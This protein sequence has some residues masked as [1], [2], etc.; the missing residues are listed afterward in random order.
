MADNNK[1]LKT[2]QDYAAALDEQQ[3]L[4]LLGE[5]VT[6]ELSMK[7]EAANA[8]LPTLT[9]TLIEKATSI[10]APSDKDKKVDNQ[11]EVL[12]ECNEA[13]VLG[14]DIELHHTTAESLLFEYTKNGV[15]R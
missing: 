13:L 8:L 4:L 5:G 11:P 1:E 9:E 3:E 10:V 15:H 14:S 7:E 6:D 2:L 12:R